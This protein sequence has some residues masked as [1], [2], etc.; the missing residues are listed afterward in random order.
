MSSKENEEACEKVFQSCEICVSSGRPCNSKKISL[1]HINE[2]FNEELQADFMVVYIKEKKYFVLNIV[3]VGRRYGERM[4]AESRG[5]AHLME[6]METEWTYHHGAPKRF[7]ADPEFCKRFFEI[8]LKGHG[9]ELK[10]RPARASY[11]NG[12]LE[13]N[14]GVFKA[15]LE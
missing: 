10:P 14:N 12:R 11:K 3:D 15:V 4:I 8:F 6:M 1:S 9:I 13:R 7:G 2:D 5:A